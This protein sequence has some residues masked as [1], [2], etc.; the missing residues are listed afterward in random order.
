MNHDAKKME[1]L[2][3][4]LREEL[5]SDGD[6]PESLRPENAE[7]TFEIREMAARLRDAVLRGDLREARRIS[8]ERAEEAVL[9]R[10]EDQEDGEIPELEEAERRVRDRIE[11]GG[12]DGDEGDLGCDDDPE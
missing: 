7:V 11:S 9:H 10:E 5:L 4:R 2:R 3:R 6:L 8:L 12:E 1:E